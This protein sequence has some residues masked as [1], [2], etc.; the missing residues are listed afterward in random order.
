[1]EE[2]IDELDLVL[3]Q[4]IDPR[5]GVE[6]KAFAVQFSGNIDDVFRNDVDLEMVALERVFDCLERENAAGQEFSSRRGQEDRGGGRDGNGLRG[7]RCWTF[8]RRGWL[9]R[10]HV[11]ARG[12]NYGCGVTTGQRRLPVSFSSSLR[13][14]SMRA[15]GRG[16]QPGIN[17][18]T[19]KSLSTP[20]TTAYCP[21]K[22]NGPPEM[23]QSP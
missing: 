2:I 23:A 3:S 16:G 10:V 1:M 4:P 14:P 22:T 8:R 15:S 7:F 5:Y 18:S 13:R 11:E 20:S 21:G 6:S 17:T 12:T 19:G 9:E